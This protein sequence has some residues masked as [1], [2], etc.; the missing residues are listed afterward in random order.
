M[1]NEKVC[2]IGAGSWG[3]T[4]AL[5]LAS[6]GCAVNLWSRRPEHADEMTA[7]RENRRYLPGS[8]FP[9]SLQPTS[10]IAKALEG[11]LL[12]ILAVPSSSMRTIANQILP[13]IDA[14]SV[15]V[16][17]TKGI[18]IDTGLRMTRVLSDILGNP[19]RVTALSGPNI[20]GEVVRRIP[21]ASVIAGPQEAAL[22][23][24]R[25]LMTDYFRVY[26]NDD[27]IG[28]ELGGALKNIMAIGAGM[29]DGL[30]YGDNTK[31]ALLTRCLVEMVRMGKALGARQETFY[32]LSGLGDLMVTSMSR[33]SRNRCFGEAVGKGEK[34]AEMLDKTH[35]VVEGVPTARATHLLA[36]K[37]GIEMPVTAE[38]YA[39][40]YEGKDPR[41]V[42]STLMLRQPKPEAG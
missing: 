26:T 16:S 24:Q 3:T 30:G 7:G 1:S 17:A 19:D 35:M 40:L 4:L 11:A 21:T 5:M 25:I 36:L 10:D 29:S 41:Q 42:V 34:V 22:M 12:V 8:P 2:I 20:S 38:I 31:A 37:M 23:A 27:L 15:I 32:G 28:V 6:G 33:H 18:E 9:D 13:F 14:Q 39:V